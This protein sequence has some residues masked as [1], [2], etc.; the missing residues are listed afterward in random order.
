MAGEKLV[1]WDAYGCHMM[2]RVKSVV[3]RQAKTDLS[4]F[5]GGL[6][7]LVQL[8]DLSWYKPFKSKYKE[9]TENNWMGENCSRP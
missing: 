3:D 9:L 7:R 4:I 1:I 5:P 2:A 8:A 6:T